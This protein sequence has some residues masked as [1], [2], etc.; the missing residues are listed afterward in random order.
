MNNIK[1]TDNRGTIEMILETCNIGSIS[2]IQSVSGATRANH[3]HPLDE[4]TIY[5]TKGVMEIYERPVGSNQKPI[6]QILNVG[7]KWHTKCM[8]EHTM[9]FNTDCDIFCFSKLPRV[10]ENYEKETIRFNH[11]LRDIYNNWKD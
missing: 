6:K 2:L 10:Q 8:L 7:D 9:Y 3:Y 1:H 11:D 4:H 5:I